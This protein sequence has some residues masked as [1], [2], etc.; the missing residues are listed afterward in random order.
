MGEEYSKLGARITP[1]HDVMLAYTRMLAGPMDY[2]P[3]GFDNVT[4]ADFAPHDKN[5]MVMGTRAH[6]LALYVVF[7]SPL[8]TVADD[9]EAYRRQKDFDFIKAV[10]A[11]WDSTKFVNGR[12]GEFVTIARKRGDELYLGSITN[13][14]AREVEIPLEFLGKGDYIAE[15]Y[16]DASDA[17][18]NPI[19]T[20]IEQKTRKRVDEVEAQPGYGRR[21]A[22]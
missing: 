13:W 4:R 8:T 10:P 3:G 5:P 21:R 16:S 22:I 6:Q 9:P 11:S 7:E 15:V 12:I 1:E 17:D 18:V 14:T 19:H 2:T 20:A